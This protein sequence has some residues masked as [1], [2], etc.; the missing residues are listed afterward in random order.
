MEEERIGFLADSGEN[1]TFVQGP[2]F[3]AMLRVKLLY[4][5]HSRFE[6]CRRVR[7]M[8]EVHGTKFL[9]YTSLQTPSNV[10]LRFAHSRI[11]SLCQLAPVPAMEYLCSSGLE[12][13]RRMNVRAFIAT[14]CSFA[15]RSPIRC[16]LSSATG[17]WDYDSQQYRWDGLHIQALCIQ[18]L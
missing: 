6:L 13:K 17:R 12:H 8:K 16:L 3:N 11:V 7:C 4:S 2:A 9:Y 18:P 10:N 5:F 14:R 15:T 1:L